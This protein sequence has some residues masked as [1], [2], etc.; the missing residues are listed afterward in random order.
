[1]SKVF[2]VKVRLLIVVLFIISSFLHQLFYTMLSVVA[3]STHP[4]VTVQPSRSSESDLSNDLT[5]TN[6]AKPD[7]NEKTLSFKKCFLCYKIILNQC[8]PV[9]GHSCSTFSM[10]SKKTKIEL[11]SKLYII[12]YQLLQRTK[13]KK[14]LRGSI[15]WTYVNK[16]IS[17][18][19]EDYRLLE[20]NRT[21]F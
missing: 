3:L 11:Y 9:W 7:T 13:P 10:F 16:W 19:F 18:I 20:A 5:S 12:L 17:N 6:A 4:K 15:A 8:H 2:K 14:R 21:V 1:M